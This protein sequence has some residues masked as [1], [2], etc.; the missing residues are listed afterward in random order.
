MQEGD[1]G[2]CGYVCLAAMLGV[3]GDVFWFA[4]M[5]CVVMAMCEAWCVANGAKAMRWSDAGGCL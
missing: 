5:V 3:W 1:A 2:V 4:V